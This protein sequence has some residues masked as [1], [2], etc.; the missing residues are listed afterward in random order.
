MRCELV[1]CEVWAVAEIVDAE[2][3]LLR[4]FILPSVRMPCN[5]FRKFEARHFSAI[6][7]IIIRLTSCCLYGDL[8]YRLS[9]HIAPVFE[10]ATDKRMTSEFTDCTKGMG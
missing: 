5:G 9:K 8:A 2:Q 6:R 7:P 4:Q 3:P 1:T 10:A